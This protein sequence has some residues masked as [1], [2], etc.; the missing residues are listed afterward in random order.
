MVPNRATHHIFFCIVFCFKWRIS[1]P[2]VLE[3]GIRN[4]VLLF[5][6][7]LHR[8]SSPALL[9]VF[10]FWYISTIEHF[11]LHVS[12][13]YGEFFLLLRVGWQNQSYTMT[14]IR[15][16][17]YFSEIFSLLQQVS[18]KK[19]FSISKQLVSLLRQQLV[20]DRGGDRITIP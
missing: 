19:S 12:F 18:L 7:P 17:C 3:G 4:S 9:W 5:W 16:L 11:K 1:Y 8:K 6:S 14:E 10:S 13:T 15:D 20:Y 2:L